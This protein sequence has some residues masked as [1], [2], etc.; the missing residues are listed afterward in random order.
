MPRGSFS[1]SSG[2]CASSRASGGRSTGSRALRVGAAALGVLALS[3]ALASPRH[4][5]LAWNL[6]PSLPEGL[7]VRSILEAP[8]VGRTVAILTPPAVADYYRRIG[9]GADLPT[10]LKPL[11]AGP[12]DHV[13][14]AGGGLAINGRFVARVARTDRNGVPLPRWDGCRALGVDE[15][16]TYAPRIPNSLD[17]RYYGPVR[18]ADIVGV[19]RP[20]WTD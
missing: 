14:V 11:A 7:Y 6:T 17:G 15:W 4:K 16:F 2:S 19:Y 1:W 10:V 12:G 8:A 18:E 9:A 20:A 3:A 13:C 5:P